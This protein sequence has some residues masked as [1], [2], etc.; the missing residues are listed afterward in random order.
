MALFGVPVALEDAP[1]R[2]C[3]AAIEIQT[4]VAAETNDIEKTY[5]LRP[6]MRIGINTGPM[7]V[8]EMKS[9]DSS[10]VTA[11]GDTVNLAAR[12]QTLAAPG[13]V[14]LS[15]ATQRLVRGLT[16]IEPAGEYTVKGK[17]EKQKIYRLVGMR[18]G[19][20]RFDR[21]KSMGLTAYVGRSRELEILERGFESTAK[22]MQI[23]DVVGEAGIGKSRLLHEFNERI[24]DKRVFMLSGSCTPD[25]QQTPFLP[26]IDVV[27]GSF[28]VNEGEAESEIA[29]KLDKGLAIL[30]LASEQN[31]G[32]LLN[33]LGLK[34]PDGSLK[35][36]DSVV[37]GLRTRDLLLDLLQERC[38]IM[39]VV[40]MLE[41]LHWTDSASEEVLSRVVGLN[42]S[43][44]LLV[45]H[46][47]RP[48]YELS[49]VNKRHV[50]MLKLEPLAM[51]HTS[52]IIHSRFGVSTLPV[53][54]VKLIT[55]KVEGNP[56]FAEEIA[57]H[58]VKR[59]I[60]RKTTHGLEYHEANVAVALPGSIQSLL[61]ARADRLSP[62]DRALLQAAAVIGRRFSVETLA[63]IT[64]SPN[65]YARLSA[66]QALDLIYADAGSGEFIF[67][68]SLVRDALYDSLL[69]S[70]RS[71]LHLKIATEIEQRSHNRL[72]EVAE[73]LAHHYGQTGRV[74]K[75][76]TY[77]V[78]AGEKAPRIYS[79]ADAERCFETAL[80]ILDQHPDIVSGVDLANLVERHSYLL[81]IN[82]RA[83]DICSLVERRLPQIEAAGTSPQL[84]KILHHYSWARL[85]RARYRACHDVP[86]QSSHTP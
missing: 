80:K 2:A 39:P 56:L 45:I 77:L 81:N 28:R 25:G 30:G 47:R 54:L 3:R 34:V 62:E 20:A 84:V 32:L 35:G 11:I 60:V 50:N 12:L 59:G 23:I 31:L 73:A 1:L 22:G 65:I 27:R 9:S 51:T 33:L 67:K 49:W 72:P 16:N 82:T 52:Q 8:G 21:S 40:M 43:L 15:E 53:E 71:A 78:M 70:P 44:S 46:T 55:D 41:D 75:W 68:H 76:Y 85:T 10:G 29:R 69:K 38:R 18:R 17:A 5:R 14:V 63:T 6:K 61:S 7:I 19:A 36:L 66:I 42:Q 13:D 79:L 26:F 86:R 48:E 4:R 37:V 64:G 74:D 24:A 57:N 83:R 58:L